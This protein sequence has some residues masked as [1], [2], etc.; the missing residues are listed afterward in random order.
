M[1]S[2]CG[3]SLV[4]SSQMHLDATMRRIYEAMLDLDEEQHRMQRLGVKVDRISCAPRP[5]LCHQSIHLN[6]SHRPAA[7]LTRNDLVTI[8]TYDGPFYGKQAW[9]AVNEAQ[10]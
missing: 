8:P 2:L 5:P 9:F 10:P 3:T 4:V 6:A 1:E 7:L